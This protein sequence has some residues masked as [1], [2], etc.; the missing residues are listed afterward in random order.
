MAYSSCNCIICAQ[1][2]NT[3]ELISV[4]S[5]RV[6]TTR[7]KICQSCLD[8]S[9]PADD[10]RQARVIVNSYLKLAEVQTLFGEVKKIINLIK[11]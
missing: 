8:K 4:V 5:S 3:N 1:E 9:D 6:N 7:F 11:S 2:F 10:Y